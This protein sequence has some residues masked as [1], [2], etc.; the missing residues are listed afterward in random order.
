MVNW[1]EQWLT[2]MR[3][4]VVVDGDV[5]NCKYILS[6]VPQISIGPTSAYLTIDIQCTSVEEGVTCNILK[7]ADDITRFRNN[8]QNWHK[9]QLQ[10]GIDALISGQKNGRCY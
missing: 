9:Q 8:K 5:S 1:I 3:Q 7:F 10:D 4:R 2:D 6:G